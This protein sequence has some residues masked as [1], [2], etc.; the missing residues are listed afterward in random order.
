MAEKTQIN[1]SKFHGIICHM[2]REG[3]NFP[4]RAEKFEALKPDP[5]RLAKKGMLGEIGGVVMFG[6]RRR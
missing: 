5:D 2:K 3:L 1:Q 6:K 4:L